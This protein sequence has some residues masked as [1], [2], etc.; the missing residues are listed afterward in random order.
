[1]SHGGVRMNA[2]FDFGGADVGA[3]DGIRWD[4]CGDRVR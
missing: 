4:R 3:V 1:M 2:C